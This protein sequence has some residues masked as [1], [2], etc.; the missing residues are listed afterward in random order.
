LL[1]TKIYR[2]KPT[3]ISSWGG[4]VSGD[5]KIICLGGGG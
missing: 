1:P 2:N 3:K 4:G 5:D